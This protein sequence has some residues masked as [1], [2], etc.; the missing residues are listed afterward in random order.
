MRFSPGPAPGSP[1]ITYY[2][3]K[4]RATSARTVSDAATTAVIERVH[5]QN[6]GIYGVRKAPAEL[7]RQGHPVARCTVAR[8][9]KAAGLHG[10]SRAKAPRTT[11]PGPGIDTRADL[12]QRRGHRDLIG[13]AVSR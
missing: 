8:M 6:C 10:I 9:M 2:A 1:R 11:I 7:N 3:A 12:V 5:A 4:T 13:P